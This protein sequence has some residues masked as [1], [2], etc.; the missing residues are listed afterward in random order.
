MTPSRRT[1][2]ITDVEAIRA[3]MAKH[4]P[5]GL[6]PRCEIRRVVI[7]NDALG[8]V[9]NLVEELAYEGRRCVL[10]VD[11]TLI[12]RRDQ[13]VKDTVESALRES[14]DVERVCLDDGHPTLHADDGVLDAATKAVTGA[15]VVVT[16]GGGTITDVGKWAC[17]RAQGRPRLV[18]VQTAASVDGF[19]DDVSVVLRSGVKRTVPTCWPD[20]VV[21]DVETIA[22]APPSM[23]RAGFGEMLSMF[24]APAD[25]F[26]ASRLGLDDSFHSAP[27]TLLG[28]AGQRI[29]EWSPGV[30]TGDLDSVRRLVESLVVR[31]ITTGLSGSTA[32]LSGMEH[33]VSHMLDLYHGQR[34]EPIGLHGAQVGVGSLLAAA[35]W[36]LL[37]ERLD[38]GPPTNVPA[39]E[40]HT[41]WHQRVVTAFAHLDPT[42]T[43]ADECWKDFS[44]KLDAWTRQRDGIAS[45]L[46]SWSQ[47]RSQVRD[48]VQP[49]DRLASALAAA[50][51]VLR[52]EHLDP[53]V[54]PEVGRWVVENCALMRNRFTVV[55]LLTFLGWWQPEDV[56]WV[57][58]RARA[59][60]DDAEEKR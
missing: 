41:L 39:V 30:A 12:R 44:R 24:T 40:D 25:W 45:A 21:C 37:F 43:V 20:F 38:Q 3:F 42:G 14:F 52:F 34:G 11:A 60:A 29:E 27:I 6:L 5:Q 28:T 13:D 17:S 47:W 58:E 35:A 18:V 54:P 23:N 2:A 8:A 59:A 36:E 48:M 15:D 33:L 22:Q 50:N 31:G 19:T 26:L 1:F 32:V 53:G 46:T 56:T 9:P 55:D 10:L 57:L 51:G 49:L 7:G 4:D 16:V